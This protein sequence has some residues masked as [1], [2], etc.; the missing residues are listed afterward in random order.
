MGENE[1]RK[2]TQRALLAEGCHKRR[3]P[4]IVIFV[5]QGHLFLR[6][7]DTSTHHPC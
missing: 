2:M 4:K 5:H 7:K 6:K 3:L 1:A